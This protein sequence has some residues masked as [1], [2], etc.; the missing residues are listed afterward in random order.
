MDFLAYIDVSLISYFSIS[1]DALR[2]GLMASLFGNSGTHGAT[3]QTAARSKLIVRNEYF[4][5]R[6]S[7]HTILQ[8]NDAAGA[9]LEHRL[10]RKL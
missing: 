7:N 1:I 10:N 3:H 9:F 4:A 6:S 8:Y 2:K 5:S